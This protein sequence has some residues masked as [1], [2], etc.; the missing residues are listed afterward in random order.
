MRRATTR[1]VA[2]LAGLAVLASAC[3]IGVTG[4]G[5]Y[6]VNIELA[7]SY[8]LFPGSP[9][10]VM[11]VEVGVVRDLEVSPDSGVVTAKLLV[12]QNVQLPAEVSARVIPAALLGERYVQLEPPYT[13]GPTFEP[14]GTVPVE[15]TQVPA[16]FDEVLESLNDFVGGLDEDELARLISNLAETLE[17]QGE[18]LGRTIDNARE[19]V[20]VLR[21]NDE[22][23]VR[24]ARRLSDLNETLATR[25]EEIGELIDDWNTVTR[26]L[27]DERGDID[28]ALNGL[29]RLTDQLRGLLETH[30]GNLEED[31]A[32]LTRVG[33]TAVRNLDQLTLMVLSSA[34]LFRHSERVFDFERNWLP[35]V[36]HTESLE[37]EIA[38]S[39]ADRLAG[40]CE[41][42]QDQ[43]PVPCDQIDFDGLV[44]G[45]VCLPPAVSCSPGSK[46]LADGLTDVLTEVPELRDA[47][48]SDDS[49][50]G[51][52]LPSTQLEEGGSVRD[53]SESADGGE[54]AP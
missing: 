2:V 50:G 8:N 45:S 30:R 16:E 26:T 27:A 14:G 28:T 48:D 29:A 22:E 37:E 25:D 21:E 20:G 9:V 15:R 7:A 54:V 3:S 43:L 18:P 38:G 1:L 34:E 42:V 53:G 44:G 23:L 6:P 40:R 4:A 46:T 13:E 51:L 47:L 33:R 52:P 5:G 35:L 41:N 17:G 24:L 31:I 36:N 19:I 10:R 39:V 12:E 49:D 32:T 11:G